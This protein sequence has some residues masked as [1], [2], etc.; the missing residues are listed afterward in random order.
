MEKNGAGNIKNLEFRN[1]ETKSDCCKVI[2][3]RYVSNIGTLDDNISTKLVEGRV[4]RLDHSK[5]EK[6]N[7]H[8]S[9]LLDCS[10]RPINRRRLV[11]A[12][13]S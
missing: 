13:F 5:G 1:G 2:N 12:M 4:A 10:L 3:S 7:L 9:C 8:C 6:D 11:A